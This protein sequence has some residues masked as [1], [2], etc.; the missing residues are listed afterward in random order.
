MDYE[1]V[2]CTFKQKQLLT[3]LSVYFSLFFFNQLGKIDYDAYSSDLLLSKMSHCSVSH[4]AA[5]Q[6]HH[7]RV[8]AFLVSWWP[9]AT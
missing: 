7:T 5:V 8:Y 1:T 3:P 4:L 9:V 2:Y 6:P